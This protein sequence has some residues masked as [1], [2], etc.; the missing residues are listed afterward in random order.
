MTEAKDRRYRIK[1]DEFVCPIP[2]R[3]P[4]VINPEEDAQILFDN[5][6]VNRV[7]RFRRECVNFVRIETDENGCSSGTEPAHA[8]PMPFANRR[9]T[10]EGTPEFLDRSVLL[11]HAPG[12]A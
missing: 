4:R 11:A 5:G 12:G 3:H 1:R 9:A 7:P 6:A 8:A 10:V 2:S